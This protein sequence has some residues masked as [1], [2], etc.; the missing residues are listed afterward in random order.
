MSVKD[1]DGCPSRTSILYWHV[2]ISM[3]VRGQDVAVKTVRLRVKC[4]E[5]Q[6]PAMPVR[7]IP[8]ASYPWPYLGH[9][10]KK[11]A[12]KQ[13]RTTQETKTQKHKTRGVNIP[14]NFIQLRNRVGAYDQ[15]APQDG[16]G[17]V[18]GARRCSVPNPLHSAT[19]LC[20]QLCSWLGQPQRLPRVRLHLLWESQKLQP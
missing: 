14:S 2:I 4:I 13:N 6:I 15:S 17:Y 20:R 16:R 12:Q 19:T 3:Y 18:R 8:L 7:C 11:R 9:N 5:L 1:L 10:S